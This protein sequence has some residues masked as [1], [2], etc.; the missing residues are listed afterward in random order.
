VFEQHYPGM[1]HVFPGGHRMNDQ[2]VTHVLLPYI[3][4]LNII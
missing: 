4:S 2:V 1:T 3:K